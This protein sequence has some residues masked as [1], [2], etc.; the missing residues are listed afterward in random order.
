MKGPRMD[1]Q[2]ARFMDLAI[3]L[4]RRGLGQVWPNPAVGCVVVRAGIIVGRGWT[5]AGGRPHAE[6][7]ALAQADAA[8]RGGTAYV[9]LEPCAHHGRTPPCAAALVDAGVARVVSAL[10]DPDPRVAGRGHAMLRA[11][12]V[13]VTEGVREADARAAQAGF[14]SRIE[15]GRPLVTLKLALTLD[16]RIATGSGESRWIT[17]PEARRAVHG[18]RASHDAVLVGVGTALA[19]DPD[20]RVRGLGI[21]GGPVRLVADSRLSVPPDGR[22]GR[23]A[24]AAPVWMLHTRAAGPAARRAWAA[25]GA[26]LVEVPAHAAGR[27][28]PAAM[29][30]E[31]GA[32][33]LTRVLCEGGGLLAASLLRAGLVDALAVFSSGKVIGAEGRAGVGP[34]AL[35]ALADAP[36]FDLI[37]ARPLAGDIMHLWHRR[38]S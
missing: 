12:G 23:S 21:L 3:A 34:L 37:E 13:V 18:L 29:L 16:G 38:E 24:G 30:A 28:D 15:R 36:A 17:G 6:T 4:G 9:S 8:A 14:L 5:A 33:G 35:A 11:A 2:D 19:D 32:R 26:E 1:A 20:L 31:L 22:L 10:R 7:Q 27:I 25:R